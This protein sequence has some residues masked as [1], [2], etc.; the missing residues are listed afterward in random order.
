MRG[1]PT[2]LI[3]IVSAL[4]LVQAVSGTTISV[5]QMPALYVSDYG[6]GITH[7]INNYNLTPTV[8]VSNG[9]WMLLGT[10]DQ[11]TFAR[12]DARK[13][14]AFSA[15][16]TRRYDVANSAPYRWYYLY[17]QDGF[18]IG[19]N[20]EFHLNELSPPPSPTPRTINSV[21]IVIERVPLVVIA[22]FG[23]KTMKLQDYTFI[24]SETLPGTQSWQVFGTND[25]NMLGSGDPNL[26]TLL[27]NRSGIGF[28]S[29]VPQQYNVTTSLDFQYYV[30]YFQS[31]FS[32]GGMNLEIQ[33]HLSENVTPTP[34]PTV[35]PTPTPTPPV[36]PVADFE[37][38]P[39]AGYTPLQVSFTD[40]STGTISN[41]SWTFGDG[42]TSTVQDPVHTYTGTGWFHVNLTVCNDAGCSWFNRNNYIFTAAPAPPPTTPVYYIRIGGDGG[43]YVEV[44]PTT[45]PTLTPSSTP[46][47]TTTATP[48]PE[49]T[50]GPMT[51]VPTPTVPTQ[52]PASGGGFFPKIGISPLTIAVGT[53]LAIGLF[54]RRRM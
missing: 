12:I 54:F 15:R 2:I 13:D 51:E 24:S 35:T 23:K 17:L 44:N 8:A 37:G 7:A 39:R 25:A 22:D 21:V 9:A 16:Q 53:L 29:G 18:S 5:T 47:P 32:V 45:I 50:E 38:S 11:A 46:T 52:T 26:F 33:F 20:L 4:F 40:R 31:G 1:F 27:D 43:G 34:T 3:S 36:P 30:I 41:W 48:A 42:G 6:A 28:V 19:S 14:V 49:E 10:N